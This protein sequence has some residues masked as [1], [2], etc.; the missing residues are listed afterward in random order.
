VPIG[1]TNLQVQYNNAGNLGGMSG[2]AWDNTNQS[3]A[4]SGATLTTSAPVLDMS[5]TWNSSGTTFT[6][7]KFNAAGTSST[8]SSATSLL[9]DLQVGTTSKFSVRKDGSPLV[10]TQFQGYR[11]FGYTSPALAQVSG[12]TGINNVSG[13]VIIAPDSNFSGGYGQVMLGSYGVVVSN[14]GSFSFNSGA[15]ADPASSA[16]TF[17]SRK[18]TANLRFGQADAATA[19]PQLLSVQS[20]VTGTTDGNGGNWTLTGSQ[21]TGTGTAGTI[22]LQTS[23]S[24]ASTG[25]GQNALAAVA[26]F[27]PS[28]LRLAQ[29]TPV[30]DLAQTW[31]TS[32]AATALKLNVTDT[33]SDY[34]S[35]LADFQ[36][37]GATSIN[38]RKGGYITGT[39]TGTA[40]YAFINISENASPGP[41]VGIS[42]GSG[43]AGITALA[44]PYGYLSVAIA[45]GVPLAFS[46]NN[47]ALTGTKDLFL[48]RKAAAKLQLGNFD[49]AVP[50]AQTLSVQS[51]WGGVT[52][53]VSAAAYPLTIQGAQG[54]GSGAGGSIVFQVAPAGTAGATSQNTLST[55]LTIAS[56]AKLTIASNN[57]VTPASGLTQI[58]MGDRGVVMS[59][60]GTTF[61]VQPL[62]ISASGGVC[63]LDNGGSFSMGATADVRLFRDAA[64]TLAQRNGVN[65]QTFRTYNTYTDASNYE[66]GVFDWTT[67]ANT[68]TIGTQN[69]GTGSARNL[70]FVVG[71]VTKIDYGISSAGMWTIN[72]GNTSGGALTVIGGTSSA[73][74]PIVRF[75]EAGTN[76]LTYNFGSDGTLTIGRGQGTATLVNFA[77]S[78]PS[79]GGAFPNTVPADFTFNASNGT[80]TGG[81]GPF[82]FKTAVPVASGYGLPTLTER[83]RITPAGLLT[84]GGVTSSFPALKQSTTTLQAR[85]ADDSAFTNIQGKLTTDNAYTA[86]ALLT[87]SGYVTIYDSTGTAYKVLVTT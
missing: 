22:I 58:A 17:L 38:I 51:V 5:Q 15:S 46:S 73:V 54:T 49:A 82:I 68:L 1:G 65:A 48:T 63:V 55:A 40:S 18:T 44:I 80:G 67:T 19:V 32:G 53:D 74:S 16:D 78:G 30:L 36:A 85:L 42:M 29:A 84:F 21:S 33:N 47:N 2:T 52:A 13:G 56:D 10:G 77:I 43:Q 39:T 57:P 24:A 35:T 9:M 66:R 7:V 70:Q 41:G 34:R 3:L 12:Y 28:T 61:G 59:I 8:N 14:T 26:T 23:S 20:V 64:N 69:A 86:N 79:N 25:T 72:S 4:I 6:G 27:G 71:G 60:Y 83:L 37:N 81:S 11:L 75:F 31:N 76:T 87:V 45:S 50:V 62:N